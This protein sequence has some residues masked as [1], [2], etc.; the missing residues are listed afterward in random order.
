MKRSKRL[1]H[2]T[3]AGGLDF[4]RG[5]SGGMTALSAGAR[6]VARRC[7]RP[8]QHAQRKSLRPFVVLLYCVV[9]YACVCRLSC[10]VAGVRGDADSYHQEPSHLDEVWMLHLR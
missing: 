2:G 3:W 10:E 7:V 6:R 5:A 1:A 4:W 8:W 9:C